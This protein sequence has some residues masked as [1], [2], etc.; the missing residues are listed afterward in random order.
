[1]HNLFAIAS[2]ITFIFMIYRRQWIQ[3]ISIFALLLFP[4]TQP[5]Q[6]PQ[7]LTVFLLSILI[8]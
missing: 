1:M 3:D 5:S 4:H 7:V 8:E 6:L 2:R